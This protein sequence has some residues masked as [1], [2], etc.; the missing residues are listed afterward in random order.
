MDRLEVSALR[1]RAVRYSDRVPGML[2][3]VL[4]ATLGGLQATPL[5][6]SG[7][8]GDERV[9]LY[10]TA[11]ALAPDARSW[12]VPVHFCVY[13]PEDGDPLR[14]VALAPLRG[15]LSV[16]ADGA[17]RARC[18]E[19]ARLFLVD[20]ER[21]KYVWVR[22]GARDVR[23]GP[24]GPDG[25]CEAVVDVPVECASEYA[26]DG[27]LPIEIGGGVHSR[28][29]LVAQTGRSVISDIDDTLKVTDVRD[30]RE[31]LANTFLREFRPVPGMSALC[32]RLAAGNATFHYVSLGP[33]QLEPLLEE[34]LAREGFPAGTLDLQ[35]FRVAD[36]DFA[37]LVGDSRA[38]K[39]AAIEPVLA[40]WPKRRFTLLG[41]S[42]QADPEVYGELA[43]RHPEQIELVL[44]RDVTGESADAP[45][46][47][48]AFESLPRERWRILDP[49]GV[50]SAAR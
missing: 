27:F 35:H 24:T 3:S 13:E 1:G 43:R 34:F 47:A 12:R 32:A 33:W 10:P 4:L 5:P 38:L 18:V 39:L 26:R 37:D 6:P 15:L 31:N 9:V 44:I 20:H 30:A 14:E 23:L 2:P 25:H 41:D 7:L 46:F 28:A 21:D 40:A 29:T 19:R 48:R 45:R 50:D 11:A 36:G 17:E 49:A 8:H 16:A 42:G 22:V